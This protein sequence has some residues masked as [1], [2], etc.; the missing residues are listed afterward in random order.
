M[1]SQLSGAR[2]D[3]IV[4]KMYFGTYHIEFNHRWFSR[5]HV[6]LKNFPT[7]LQVP[8]LKITPVQTQ[9]QTHGGK[10]KEM[11][12]RLK[13][14]LSN[15]QR[16]K[17]RLELQLTLSHSHIR[18]EIPLYWE[19]SVTCILDYAL[20][21]PEYMGCIMDSLKCLLACMSNQ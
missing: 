6:V 20:R 14:S 18:L 15:F 11:N 12:Y 7:T 19:I 2:L 21:F 10:S 4:A 5:T 3:Y 16:I 9:K 17:D 1:E 8:R 13:N